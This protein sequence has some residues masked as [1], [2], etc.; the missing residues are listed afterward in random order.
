MSALPKHYGLNAYPEVDEELIAAPPPWA[1]PAPT[2][3]PPPPARSARPATSS[4]ANAADAASTAAVDEDV[5]LDVSVLEAKHPAIAKA[6]VV[7]WGSREMNEY[8][9]Q[10]CLGDGIE[11][12]DPDAMSDLMLL[13]RIH[14]SVVPNHLNP[15]SMAALYDGSAALHAPK[16]T[17]DHSGVGGRGPRRAPVSPLHRR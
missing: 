6:V 8:L 16:K 2:R 5:R 9:T 10:L 17:A 14:H 12:I 15:H 3:S 11:P 4:P 13:S 1:R 7:L